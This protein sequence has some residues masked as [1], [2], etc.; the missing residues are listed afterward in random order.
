MKS[1]VDML[2]THGKRNA[3]IGERPTDGIRLGDQQVLRYNLLGPTTFPVVS[4]PP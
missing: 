1:R 2:L 4:L 3:C